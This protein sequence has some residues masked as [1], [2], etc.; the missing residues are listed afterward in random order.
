MNFMTT[1]IAKFL[2]CLAML[3][4]DAGHAK[5]PR[6]L[7]LPLPIPVL[8]YVVRPLIDAPP[9]LVVMNHGETLDPKERSF[10]PMVEFRDAAFWFARRGGAAARSLRLS[11]CWPAYSTFR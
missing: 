6:L 7:V 10:Y 8:G 11:Q 9:P 4:A 1:I 5:E 3:S 2:V